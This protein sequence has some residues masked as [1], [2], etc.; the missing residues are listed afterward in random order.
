MPKQ[1]NAMIEMMTKMDNI[2]AFYTIP[3]LHFDSRIKA[4]PQL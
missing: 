1:I 3:T 4:A 2:A